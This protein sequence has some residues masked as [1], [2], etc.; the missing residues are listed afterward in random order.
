MYKGLLADTW[1]K[2]MVGGTKALALGIRERIY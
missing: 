1:V 2:V